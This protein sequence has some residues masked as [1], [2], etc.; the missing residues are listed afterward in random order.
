MAMSVMSKYIGRHLGHPRR[1]Q[2]ITI[3]QTDTIIN[4]AQID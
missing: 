3:R 2:A 1:V 4:G